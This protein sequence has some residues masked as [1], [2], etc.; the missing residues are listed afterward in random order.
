M[1]EIKAIDEIGYAYS[2]LDP[3]GEI[4]SFGHH[5][6]SSGYCDRKTCFVDL[7]ES[8]RN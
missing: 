3:D 8:I 2:E 4:G 6:K 5:R 1:S 7:C